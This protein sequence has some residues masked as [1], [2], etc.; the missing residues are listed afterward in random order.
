MTTPLDYNINDE[1]TKLTIKAN[2][3]GGFITGV[4]DTIESTGDAS[5]NLGKKIKGIVDGTELKSQSQVV[6]KN[7]KRVVELGRR[8][9]N[10]FGFIGGNTG[11]SLQQ[12][13]LREI[14][15]VGNVVIDDSRSSYEEFTLKRPGQELKFGY[16]GLINYV[17]NVFAPPALVS[18]KRSKRIDETIVSTND[19]DGKESSY[20]QVV[21]NY[22]RKPIDISIK[23]LL[24]DMVNHQ[25]PSKKVKQ[26][27]ELFDYNGAWE[28]EGQ[29]FLDHKI[30]SIYFTD[31]DDSPVQ[32]FMDTWSFTLEARSIKPV[33][34]FL[35]K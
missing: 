14:K 19:S 20:G 34:Y 25:Y 6:I 24:I 18:F 8:F 21:E 3:G 35:K 13:N 29:I 11:A 10:A 23:G 27:I 17:D 4:T 12:T 31:M 2:S 1:T 33:E 26:L 5:L 22:G 32:G 9:Q 16:S 15:N 30:Y 7:G 28:V